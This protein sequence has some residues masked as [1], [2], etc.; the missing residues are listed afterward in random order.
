MEKL[1]FIPGQIYN[2][3]NEIHGVYK[4]NWQG[5]ICPS[6]T[7]PYIFIFTGDSGKQHGYDDYWDNKDVFSYTGEGQVGDM[8][9]VRGNLALRDHLDQG[10]RVFLFEKVDKMSGYVR[11]KC[12]L[13]VIDADYF[14]AP[15]R[16]GN[17][18]AAIKFFF[19]IRGNDTPFVLSDSSYSMQSK[20]P[21]N[22]FDEI[23]PNITERSG[24]VTSRVGQGAY[25][26]RIIYR[27]N[28]KCAV[29]GFDKLE[30]LIASHILPWADANNNQRLD[31]HN[32][33]LLSPVY[34]ALFDRHLISFDND[35]KIIL[36]DYIETSA[37]EKIGVSG[38]E[39]IQNLSTENNAY[40][41]SHRSTF[42]LN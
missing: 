15:D 14:E 31:V 26:K 27:W 41:E 40:L 35:G 33:L 30:V 24:L 18:R 34:D 22:L 12:E 39:R 19:K 8:Q 13:E 38:A 16:E 25:R 2:R 37:Y 7:H 6:S 21:L 32:G 28:S 1:P 11:F 10:K 3:R 36:S 20:E 42:N 9:F 23:Q 4:G 29:T 5:G 17:I